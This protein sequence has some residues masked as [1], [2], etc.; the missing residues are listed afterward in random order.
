MTT[1][2]CTELQ[3]MTY[4]LIDNAT[5]TAVQRIQGDI[6]IKNTDTI[7]GDLVAFENL[8]QAILFYDELVCIDNYKNE[9]NTSR[10]ISFDFIRFVEPDVCN[11]GQAEA[12]AKSESIKIKPKI[13]GGKFADDDF[14]SF[15][16]MIKM[17]IICTWDQRSS[18]YYLT[19]KLLGQPYTDEWSKYSQLSAT[20]FNELSDV[21]TTKGHWSEEIALVGSDGIPLTAE[22][23]KEKNSD[24][25]GTTKSLD[26][27]VASL[28]WLAYKS[29]YYST[30]AKLLNADSFLH[31]IRHAFQIHWMKKSGVYGHDFTKK[32]IDSMSQSASNS[33]AEIKDYGRVATTSFEAPIFSAWLVSESG[34]PAQVINAAKELKSTQP[35]IEIRGLLRQIRHAYDEDSLK[36]S[37]QLITKWSAELEKASTELKYLYGVKTNHGI[38]SSL[39]MNVFN[40]VAAI[41]QSPRFPD[42]GFNLKKPEFMKSPLTKSFA[43]VYKSIASELTTTERLGG[44]KD[45][46]SSSVKID[47][48][49]VF[50]NHKVEDPKFQRYSSSWKR[51]M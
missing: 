6:T 45:Y 9:H 2:L 10:K 1:Q 22:T 47:K 36:A 17:N 7:D 24:L 38:P 28:N 39:I 18:I 34:S 40:S 32:L 8:V 30:S 48:D 21:A 15:L 43:H 19:M 33:I 41:T 14:K 37:N 51:P 26:M 11:L 4:A 20:I 13:K 35:F 25:G 27:F 50:S 23:F 46:L 49:R 42:F 16:E 44:F 31:P 12:F 29:I 5:L 3:N